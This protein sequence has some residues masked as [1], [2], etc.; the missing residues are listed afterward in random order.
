MT[1][2]SNAQYANG[3]SVVSGDQLNTFVQT[4]PTSAALRSFVGKANMTVALLG[5][6]APND[7]NGGEFYWSASA[8]APDDNTNVIRPSGMTVGA[9]L[10]V[11]TV[12]ATIPTITLSGDVAGS[13]TTAITTTLA[14]VNTNVGTFQGITVNAKGLVTGAVTNGAVQGATAEFATSV[15]T[16]L[17]TTSNTALSVLPPSVAGI[18]VTGYAVSVSGGWAASTGFGGSLTLRGGSATSGVNPAGAVLT[19]NG[20]GVDTATLVTGSGAS[21][22]F[23]VTASTLALTGALTVSSTA[24]ITG[25]ATLSST[26]NV[27]GA[28]TFTAIRS[29]GTIAQTGTTTVNTNSFA[30]WTPTFT[31]S[32]GSSQGYGPLYVAPNETVNYYGAGAWNMAFFTNSLGGAGSAGNRDGVF[33]QLTRATASDP[34]DPSTRNDTALHGRATASVSNGGRQMGALDDGTATLG[35][36]FGG[37][38]QASLTGTALYYTGVN[39]F[40]VDVS[41]AAGAS[42]RNK[43]GLNIVQNS[44][45]I[46]RGSLSDVGFHFGLQS[47]GAG[48][49]W[50]TG[51]SFGRE[52]GDPAT[53]SDTTLFKVTQRRYGGTNTV[54]FARGID[55]TEGTITAGGFAF[56]SPNFA[57][58]DVGAVY[59]NGVTTNST[60]QAQTATVTSVTINN[61]GEYLLNAATKPIYTVVAPP[62]G[63]TATL[64]TNVM[65]G[66]N[67]RL[68]GSTGK[69]YLVG[70]VLTLPAATGTQPTITVTGV[71][72]NGG[73]QSVSVTTNG[74][75]TKA[76]AN[77]VY[78]TGGTGTGAGFYVTYTASTNIFV[79]WT[80]SPAATGAGHAVS[81]V[82]TIVG[83]TGTA[84]K[85]NVATVDAFG[86]VKTVTLN[87][88]GSVTVI[89]GTAIGSNNFHTAT[90]TGAGT[91]G[92]FGVTYAVSS[93]N[94]TNAGSGY[95]PSPPPFVQCSQ[96]NYLTASVTPVMTAASA[97]LS[98]N[99]GGGLVR[100]GTSTTVA[101]LGAAG[102]VGRRAIVTDANATTF[103]TIVAAG[104]AN[105]V[106]VFDDGTNWRIG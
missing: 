55:F 31:G 77:P 32:L 48:P 53:A 101:G 26:L 54:P 88:A 82:L 28:S 37:T 66:V 102:T 106:P 39:G 2:P 16:P 90:T 62:S 21:A 41:I 57:A 7:G 105:I 8:T 79:P 100:L 51:I 75:Y 99:P 22:A 93:L 83:D 12:S 94:I 40:E 76:P 68:F 59:G 34:G 78:P 3:I 15:A 67:V 19:L 10:R 70:D 65:V 44:T 104:G 20:H 97:L 80:F 72:A 95:L 73:I 45:D 98:L 49:G 84:V 36:T 25:A 81:D 18:G 58:T 87:T 71:D 14:T 103:M 29:S 60:V 24:A 85:F 5:V 6:S 47:T 27:T 91:G 33:S 35:S 69:N 92:Y 64:T 42:T 43:V 17:L 63:V 61:G 46:N 11:T 89:G 4:C 56:M 23:S 13:G 86:G 50:K 96:S 1:V 30:H 38:A 52:T 9:W 74:A